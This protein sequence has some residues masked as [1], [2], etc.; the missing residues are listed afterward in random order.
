MDNFYQWPTDDVLQ[1]VSFEGVGAD[2][3]IKFGADRGRSEYQI[4]MS[5]AEGMGKV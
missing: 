1:P 3:Q 2:S 5:Y 4:G